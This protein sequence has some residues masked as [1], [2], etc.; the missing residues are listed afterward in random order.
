[1][2]HAPRLGPTSGLLLLL[3]ALACSA[4]DEPA[5]AA[6]PS[7][8]PAAP[9]ATPDS[10]AVLAA[11]RALI[12]AFE[13]GDVAAAAALMD[14]TGQTLVFHPYLENRF[15]GAEQVRD[16]LGRMLARLDGTDWTD[17]DPSVHVRGDVAWLSS[18][19][20]VQYAGSE[21]PFVGRGTEVW[22]RIGPGTWRLAHGHWS[23]HARI[24]PAPT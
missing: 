4:P 14:P 15:E 13:R 21:T 8:V 7:A 16:G 12:E 23:E 17:V 10:D 22:I 3:C 19:V 9:S 20:L 6:A 24:A 1:M 18:Q 5:P 11:H 2:R